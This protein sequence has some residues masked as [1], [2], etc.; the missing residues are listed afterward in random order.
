MPFET[1]GR[2]FTGDEAAGTSSNEQSYS[3]SMGTMAVLSPRG[4]AISRRLELYCTLYIH[5]AAA[6]LNSVN[7]PSTR[8]NRTF[9][10]E[11]NKYYAKLTMSMCRHSCKK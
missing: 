3:G 8:G 1:R 11:R 10:A 4:S 6:A 5:V 7:I 2:W 9:T